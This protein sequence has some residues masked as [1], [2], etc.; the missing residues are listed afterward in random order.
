ME[1]LI[2]ILVLISSIILKCFG[3]PDQ[4]RK[5]YQTKNS[6]GFS[7]LYYTSLETTYLLWIAHGYYKKDWIV[8][9]TSI[10]GAIAT[11]VILFM[12]VKYR[13]RN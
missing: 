8:I 10:V 13:N 7:L 12:V 6:E 4:V 9:S 3:M 2:E 11:G 5:L 1:H